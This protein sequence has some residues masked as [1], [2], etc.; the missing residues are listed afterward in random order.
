MKKNIVIKKM[1][2]ATDGRG[3][4]NMELLGTEVIAQVANAYVSGAKGLLP[5]YSKEAIAKYYE[6]TETAVSHC[7]DHAIEF[8]LIKFNTVVRIIQNSADNERR[9]AEHHSLTR[10]EKRY[11]KLLQKRFEHFKT[12]FESESNRP[13]YDSAYKMYLGQSSLVKVMSGY[14]FSLEEMVYLLKRKACIDMTPT[15]YSIFRK[16]FYL[17]FL[18]TPDYHANVEFIS[19]FREKMSDQL[20]KLQELRDQHKKDTEEYETL[21]NSL[22]EAFEKL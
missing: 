10:S 13:K 1:K 21:R 3:K 2:E 17:N 9:H 5:L 8:G 18:G 11:A 15:E 22:V 4:V 19:S 6:T 20:T 16:K 7:I 14:G 12:E